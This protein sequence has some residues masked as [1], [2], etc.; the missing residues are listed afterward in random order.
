[1]KLPL[2]EQSQPQATESLPATGE[3]G[4]TASLPNADVGSGSSTLQ[5]VTQSRVEIRKFVEVPNPNIKFSAGGIAESTTTQGESGRTTTFPNANVASGSSTLQPATQ[6]R[7]EIRKFVEV[8]NPNIKFPAGRETEPGLPQAEKDPAISL[9]RANATSKSIVGQPIIPNRLDIRKLLKILSLAHMKFPQGAQI[10]QRLGILL[11]IV[12]LGVTAWGFFTKGHDS[13]ATHSVPSNSNSSASTSSVDSLASSDDQMPSATKVPLSAAPR[14]TASFVIG[15]KARKNA[16]VSI[17][18]D[19][20]KLT[21]EKLTSGEEKSVAAAN[22]VIVKTGNPGALDFEFNG[23]KLPVPET[24][25][26]LQTLEF[27]PS[28]LEV[29]ISQPPT[30]IRP[31]K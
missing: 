25:A 17:R 3:C 19:G 10:Q 21:E 18:A 24:S 6:N 9:S 29:I 8:P 31:G 16:W 28:G 5:P 11:L 2:A 22:Q 27:G 7:V 30:R 12:A 13:R 20:R 14:G 4:R 15:I 1:M 23:R 26:E